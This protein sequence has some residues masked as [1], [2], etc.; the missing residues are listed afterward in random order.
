VRPV[1]DPPGEVAVEVAREGGI[2]AGGRSRRQIG[3]LEF[4]PVDGHRDV[5]RGELLQAAS[6][7]DVEVRLNDAVDVV[8]PVAAVREHGGQV[9]VAG[10]RM[11]ERLVQRGGPVPVHRI[12]VRTGVPV[13]GRV[14]VVHQQVS[15]GKLRVLQVGSLDVALSIPRPTTDVVPGHVNLGIAVR[16]S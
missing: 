11:R 2:A 13:N 6:V 4:A 12:R 7:V 15:D 3:V 14:R 1:D 5:G 9:P 10:V 8:D 16:A